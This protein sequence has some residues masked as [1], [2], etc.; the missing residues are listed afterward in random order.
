VLTYPKLQ[1]RLRSLGI[2]AEDAMRHA[3]G[4]SVVVEAPAAGAI[5]PL[6]TADPDDDPFLLCAAAT[7]AEAVVSG[8]GHLL[9]LGRH[10]NIPI[11]T[12]RSFL[13]RNF[14][15]ESAG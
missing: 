13:D 5:A 8:D 12:P 15:A 3:V 6:V 2:T 14:P 11:L 9:D 10:G 4:L 7:G 1:P